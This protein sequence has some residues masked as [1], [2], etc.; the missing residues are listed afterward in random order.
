MEKEEEIAPPYF[1]PVVSR[2]NDGVI[3]NLSIFLVCTFV[4]LSTTMD[5]F[6]LLGPLGQLRIF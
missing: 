3:Q 5:P 6:G 1:D 2:D 4:P